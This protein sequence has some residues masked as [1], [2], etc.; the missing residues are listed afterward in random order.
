M[1]HAKSPTFRAAKLKGFTVCVCCVVWQL[2]DEGKVADC[3]TT[4]GVAY[5]R[6]CSEQLKVFTE[7]CLSQLQDIAGVIIVVFVVVNV[8]TTEL[9]VVKV[10]S[11]VNGNTEFLGPAT[12]KLLVQ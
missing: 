9:A 5:G 7:I 11:L 10:T 3:M 4:K 2:N 6:A 8:I 1:L 12:Q